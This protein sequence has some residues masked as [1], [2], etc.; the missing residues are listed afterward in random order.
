MSWH[1]ALTIACI[2]PAI[3]L[4]TYLRRKTKKLPGEHGP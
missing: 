2:L 3:A 4:W 1:L